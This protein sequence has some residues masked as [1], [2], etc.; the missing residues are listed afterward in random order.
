MHKRIKCIDG[1]LTST[2]T[3]VVHLTMTKKACHANCQAQLSPCSYGTIFKDCITSG[4]G[5]DYPFNWLRLQSPAGGLMEHRTRET[6]SW[7]IG[8]I[9][10]NEIQLIIC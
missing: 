8:E 7:I 6:H 3:A 10:K 4:T 1:D 9:Y 2:L 5:C